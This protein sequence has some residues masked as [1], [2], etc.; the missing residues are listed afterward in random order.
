MH[1]GGGGEA[2]GQILIKGLL[3]VG[4][5]QGDLH[6]CTVQRLQTGKQE[7]CSPHYAAFTRVYSGLKLWC[8]TEG[9]SGIGLLGTKN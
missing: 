1:D 7:G 8:G 9:V 2:V 4:W 6:Y 5:H 3:E